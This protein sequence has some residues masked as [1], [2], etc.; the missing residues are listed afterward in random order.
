MKY[1]FLILLLVFS[2]IRSST[3]SDAHKHRPVKDT[4]ILR[5]DT[6]IIR[7]DTLHLGDSTVMDSLK[8]EPKTNKSAKK[9]NGIAS[10]YSKSLDGTKTA[11]GEIYRNSKMT[12]ASNNLKLNTWVRVTNLS[13]GNTV[14]VRINDRMHPRMAKKGR[15]I[16]LSRAAAA[17]LDFMKKGLTKVQLEV[18]S[19]Q[20]VD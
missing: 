7:M 18:V 16:D 10:F 14:I 6:L 9:I 5:L 12:G 15:V 17:E 1:L 8:I 20:I 19:A 3:Q 2:G 4:L 11:T 13:N